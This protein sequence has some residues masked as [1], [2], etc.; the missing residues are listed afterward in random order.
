MVLFTLTRE[1]IHRQE[2]VLQELV[3][4]VV[5]QCQRNDH[6]AAL[7]R[8]VQRKEGVRVPLERHVAGAR[9]GKRRLA[10]Q[11]PAAQRKRSHQPD[12]PAPLFLG[13][14]ERKRPVWNP[15]P[16]LMP[17]WHHS[18]TTLAFA[19]TSPMPMPRT[20]DGESSASCS[21]TR[22]DWNAS[23]APWPSKRL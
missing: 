20:R 3:A 1:M 15:S 4:G 17:H 21:T 12:A 2:A 13:G 6:P 8:G 9:I 23:G 14:T 11:S 19:S 22:W 5:R 10:A 7:P 18:P 16:W